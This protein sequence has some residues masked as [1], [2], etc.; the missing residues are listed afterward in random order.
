MGNKKDANVGF[1]P[2]NYAFVSASGN[3]AK[4]INDLL[5][6]VRGGQWVDAKAITDGTTAEN[7]IF[8]MPSLDND[9]SFKCPPRMNHPK[10]FCGDDNLANLNKYA[11][12][13]CP[14]L[15]EYRELVKNKLKHSTATA[16]EQAEKQFVKEAR[17]EAKQAPKLALVKGFSV[18]CCEANCSHHWDTLTYV[19]AKEPLFTMYHAIAA[20]LKLV[21]GRESTPPE[22]NV[23]RIAEKKKAEME[24]P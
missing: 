1:T 18:T 2:E 7:C 14:R 4:T 6:K 23:F 20:H 3:I 8:N 24:G 17:A 16:P 22:L 9:L 5:D 12:S 21:H 11:C 13:K 15:M 19:A 10:M